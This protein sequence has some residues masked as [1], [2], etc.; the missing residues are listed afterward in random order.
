[1]S[2]GAHIKPTDLR[3]ILK[4]VPRFQGQIFIIAIDGSIVADDNIPNLL[5]D[6]AVL[7][8]LGI[9]VVIV[10]GIGQ[11]IVELA[12]IRNIAIT[13]AIGTGV[14][15]AATLDLA[16]R[17]SSR[18]THLVIEGL[19]ANALKAALTN[20]VRAMPFGIIKGVD[21]QFT[22]RV[23]RIDK[24]FFQ[25]LIT[26]GVVPVVNPIGFDRDGKPLRI[27][28]DALAAELAEA[29]QATKIIYLT[30][31]QGLEI[32]GK[33]QHNIPVDALRRLLETKPESIN[34]PMRSKAEQAIKAIDNGTPR[35][36]LIDGREPEGL[37]AEIFSN[38]GVGTLI[39]G[40]E[41]QQIRKAT[42]RDVRA[43]YNLTRSGMKREELRARSQ[44]S[45]E[46]TIDQFYVFEIDENLI[47]CISLTLYP[48]D[49]KVAEIGSLYVM[50][51]YG[52]RGI[53]K[54]MVDFACMRAGELGV[55]K[56]IALSTQAF[57]FFTSVCGFEEAD[58]DVLPE[59][60]LKAYEESGRNS[61]VL[62][63]KI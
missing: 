43:I 3:G 31:N 48:E 36:H 27:N 63:K 57:S 33:L 37:L 12:K 50:P 46:K 35:I 13:D 42:K 19:T 29:M 10:H 32:N 30:P 61:K 1:M 24:D 6:I 18:V 56:V 5:T 16:I 28:S 55:T 8:S 14:A 60:R 51:F 23:D 9:K 59:S 17:A 20:A 25:Q 52:N 45:I 4:Y 47:A 7:R 54:K 22:G 38:E 41:Y 34:E 11:Q 15:D 21:H 62:A 26:S 58:K 44:Q 2:N 39:H 49:A 53:G 40:N